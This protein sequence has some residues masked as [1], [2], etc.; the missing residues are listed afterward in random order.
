MSDIDRD[1]RVELTKLYT[2]EDVINII[3]ECVNEIDSSYNIAEVTENFIKEK[4]NKE[5]EI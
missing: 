3:W 5:K 1:D 2:E 4:F